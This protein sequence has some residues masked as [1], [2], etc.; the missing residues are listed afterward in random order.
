MPN[1]LEHF[2]ITGRFRRYSPMIRASHHTTRVLS[3]WFPKA[4]PLVHI[5][6]YPK[7]GTTWVCQLVADYLQLPHPQ[8]SIFPIGFPAIMHGH[9]T[10]SKKRPHSIYVTRDGRDVMASYYFFMIRNLDQTGKH[11]PEKRLERFFPPNADKSDIRANLPYFIKMQMTRP[12]ASKVNWADHAQSFLR[13]GMRDI[14]LLRY[15]S[16]L[17]DGQTALS[18]AITTLTGE[19]ADEKSVADALQRYDFNRQKKKTKPASDGQNKISVMRKG[20]H[21]DWKNHFT[22]EAAEVF[23]SFA[24]DTLIELGYESDDAWID[25]LPD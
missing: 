24:G 3:T 2:S 10:V 12:I 23:Q 18:N 17:E 9:Q 8:M 25:T 7:S 16:L 4:I 1:K 21:G 15:E 11:R 22:K 14:P 5:L 20:I 19:P 6:G 13:S